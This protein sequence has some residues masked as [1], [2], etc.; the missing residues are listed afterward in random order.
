MNEYSPEAMR[1]LKSDNARLLTEDNKVPSIDD[2]VLSAFDAGLL[3]GMMQVKSITNLDC[4]A[5]EVSQIN[6]P[7]RQ[8]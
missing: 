6:F 8:V 1:Y 5:K 2:R 4:Y 3:E 7:K